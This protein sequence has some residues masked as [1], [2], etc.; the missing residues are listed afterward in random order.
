MSRTNVF[1]LLIALIVSG[2]SSPTAS[3]PPPTS[4]PTQIILAANETESA[5]T[6]EP[7]TGTEG[8]DDE[9]ENPF[10]P[11]SDEAAW[12]YNISSGI[13]AVHVMSA[14]DFGKFTINITGGDSTFTVD[15]QCTP[16]GI[17]L[18]DTTYSGQ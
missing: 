7:V 9:C 13:T 5:A 11:V 1:L 6:P 10:Y 2:C 16:D 17:V 3:P 15:G 14:D 12:T 18:M 4:T 8:D